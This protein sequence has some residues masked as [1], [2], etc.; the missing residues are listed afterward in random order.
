MQF[1][2][3]LR[4][5]TFQRQPGAALGKSPLAGAGILAGG[6]LAGGAA[7]AGTAGVTGAAEPAEPAEMPG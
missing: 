5:A 1:Y 3:L 2:H 4:D 7:G 6:T